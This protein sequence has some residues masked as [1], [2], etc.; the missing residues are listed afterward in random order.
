[1]V[2][3]LPIFRLVVDGVRLDLHLAGGEIALEIL[4]IG[5][6]VPKAPFQEAVKLEGL[7]CAGSIGQTDPV[8]L[9]AM[10]DRHEK[11]H[12]SPQAILLAC[13]AGIAHP[14]AALVEIEGCLAGLPPRIPDCIAVLEIE[15]A[16]AGIHRHAVV[17]IAE[18]APE[19]GVPAEAIASGGIGNQGKEIFCTHVI[20]PGPGGCRLSHHVFASLVIEMSEFLHTSL[21]AAGR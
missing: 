20:N 12:L 15:I 8:N 16:A 11:E 13:Y 10:A 6:C 7:A 14:V 4:H 2:A 21:T 18:D 1:M 5:R 17:A 19:L 9:A 3:P